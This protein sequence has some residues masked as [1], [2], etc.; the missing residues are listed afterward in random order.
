MVNLE[1]R[2]KEYFSRSLPFYALFWMNNDNLALHYGFWYE[3]TRSLHEALVNENK[4]VAENLDI[5]ESDIILDA[6]CGVGGTSMWIAENYGAKV[7]GIN[8]VDKHLETAKRYLSERKLDHKVSFYNRDFC[9][10]GFQDES[11]TKIF[12][13]ES[14]CYAAEKGDFLKEAYRLLKPGGLLVVADG[15]R[16]KRN[17]EHRE[18]RLYDEWCEGWSVPNLSFPEDFQRE[19]V[20]VGF[21]VLGYADKT[22]EIMPSARRIYLIAIA[23][24][25]LELLL[26]F[27]RFLN[28]VKTS[29][30]R[31]IS[32]EQA[33]LNQYHMFKD[34]VVKFGLFKARKPETDT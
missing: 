3:D 26:R 16:G 4:E 18:Q 32:S 14:I 10:S 9:N 30:G 11:F 28:L 20:N 31:N 27:L 8:I 23:L 5:E 24:Y 13:I 12:G 21:Q 29:G 17:L 22:R 34:G 7:V 25:P 19:M 15:F 6:G 1:N 2:I 33:C